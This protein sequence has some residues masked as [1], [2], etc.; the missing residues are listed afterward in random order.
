MGLL[1]KAEVGLLGPFFCLFVLFDTCLVWSYLLPC[2]LF[3]FPLHTIIFC[4]LNGEPYK[5]VRRRW[6]W[7]D[8]GEQERDVG[9][10]Q[11]NSI[12]PLLS[13]AHSTHVNW[14]QEQV[15]YWV[16]KNSAHISVKI[17]SSFPL[18]FHLLSWSFIDS[19]V[20]QHLSQESPNISGIYNAP[21][22]L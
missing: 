18:S 10:W 21:S 17:T 20:S 13:R 7:K 22:W 6:Q 14:D 1:T 2:K 11:V 3:L 5:A 9:T 8:E 16:R 15:C 12:H 19:F 4:R